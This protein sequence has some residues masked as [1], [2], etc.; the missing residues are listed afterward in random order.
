MQSVA[1]FT[2]TYLPTVNGVTYTIQTWRERWQRRGGR[3]DVVYPKDDDYTPEDG[4]YPV[5]SLPFPFYEGMRVGVPRVP[6]SVAESDA[7]VVHAHTPF[8]LGLAGL[9]LA[10]RN[11]LPFVA[12]YHT[13]T[14]EYAEYLSSVE[15]IERGV[16]RTAER[17]ER[18]FF[19]RADAVIVPSE[20]AKRRLRHEVG[21][22]A[23]IVVLSNGIDIEQFAPADGDEFR[24]RYGLGDGPLVGYT[25]RH[26]FEKRLDELV[27]AA[28]GLDATL[29]FGG[30]GPARDELERLAANLDVDAR[31]LGFLDREELPAFYSALDVFGFPSPVETQ[32][33]VALEANACGTPVVGVNDGALEDTVVDGETGYHYESGDIDGFRRGIQRALA[34]RD[35][36]SARCL[37]RRDEVSVDHSVDKLASL[38]D[39]LE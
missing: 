24:E 16:E 27:R 8:G 33:L 17:Y 31:F 32:G 20:D 13:P 22:D 2:D 1:A 38:Y 9:R 30:D 19:D 10:R 3:M 18:W 12:T 7:D 34:E 6:D 14:A 11:D 37:E 21:V 35:E 23:E 29:V 25:G 36:L 39:R 26:G 15:V 4:E 5:R 28:S